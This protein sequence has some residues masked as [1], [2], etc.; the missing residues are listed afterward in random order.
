[1]CRVLHNYHH[2]TYAFQFYIF[3]FYSSS[4][5]VAKS[6]LTL[7]TLWTGLPVSS[8]HG[9]LQART[10]EWIAISFS[11]ESSQPRNWTRVSCTA[12]RFFTNW[13]TSNTYSCY[14]IIFSIIMAFYSCELVRDN[15]FSHLPIGRLVDCFHCLE[16]FSYKSCDE[17]LFCTSL[18]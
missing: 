13:A 18:A 17:L 10:L 1:M 14:F 9:I 11:R 8:V 6:C 12:G 2:S 7:V 4:S 5:L 16:V 3:S 15:W